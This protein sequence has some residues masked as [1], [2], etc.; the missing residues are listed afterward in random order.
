MSQSNCETSVYAEYQEVVSDYVETLRHHPVAAEE[1]KPHVLARLNQLAS[2]HPNDE[3]LAQLHRATIAR[4][5]GT[6]TE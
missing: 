1:I 5:A 4:Y 6:P 3:Q 2:L